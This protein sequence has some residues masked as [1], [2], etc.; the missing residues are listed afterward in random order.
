MDTFT[1]E[2]LVKR[3]AALPRETEWVEFK[4]NQADPEEIGRYISGLANAA[5]LHGQPTAYLIWGIEDENHHAVG[6]KFK[7]R[8][9]K[10]G[11]E[12][13]EP[14]ITRMVEPRP[15]LLFH[16]GNVDGSAVVILEIPPARQMP[17]AF[18]RERHIRV[19]S[20]LKPLR[21]FPEK[22]RR[23]WE[24]ISETHFE[25]DLCLEGVPGEDL[26]SS[27]LDYP[28]Y[29][30]RTGQPLPAGATGILERLSAEKLIAPRGGG[31]FDVTNL[32]AILFARDLD[33]I[34][35]LGRK[36]LR[37]ILYR[38][39]NRVETIREWKGTQG[40][41]AAYE[42]GIDWI[43]NQL[44]LNEEIRNAFRREEKTYP[45]LAIRE[46]LANALIHQDFSI[47]GAGP[48]VEIFTDRMEITNPGVPL[49]DILRLLDAP[50]RSRN[51]TLAAFMRR[52]NICEERGS[53][54]DKVF[55]KV[56]EFHLPATYFTVVEGQTRAV[57]YAP[58]S[59]KDM[60]REDRVRTCYQHAGLLWVS[61]K[62]MTNASL[63]QRLGV[64][65]Q[66]YPMASRVIKDTLAAE[67]IKHLNSEGAS[68]AGAKYLP[69][70]A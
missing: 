65:P 40:Y 33:H 31:L 28:T 24:L 8:S 63:R 35:R 23:L 60:D 34:P 50:P 68:G 15:H 41:A 59:Y 18:K 45:E 49:V 56:E 9:A 5:A 47:T 67:L 20:Y 38:G 58:K 44:P 11:G 48:M 32:G 66:N 26:L 19:G 21:E 70:W 13:F 64:D 61:G 25:M 52:I 37:I 53:G 3:L 17:V 39:T 42:A 7:P 30:Q 6:T 69:Y 27:V 62:A 10:I 16:E 46:L 55:A 36:S 43:Q 2:A 22:E 12:D 14:W 4:V 51:E 1:F 54:I 29:F 57:L